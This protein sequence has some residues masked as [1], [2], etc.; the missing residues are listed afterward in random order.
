MLH[1]LRDNAMTAVRSMRHLALRGSAGWG[2]KSRFGRRESG[3]LQF[4]LLRWASAV[5]PERT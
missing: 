1:R 5:S 4:L 2:K 3:E